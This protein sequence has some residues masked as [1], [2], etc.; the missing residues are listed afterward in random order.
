MHRRQKKAIGCLGTL[1]R[2]FG[3]PITV[4]SWGTFRKIDGVLAEDEGG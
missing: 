1:D 4:R 2:Q 3:V